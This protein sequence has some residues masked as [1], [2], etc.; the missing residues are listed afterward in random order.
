LLAAQEKKVW[1]E[2]TEW[3]GTRRLK[4]LPAH[5]WTIAAYLRWC[6]HRHRL[7]TL[8]AIL[9]VIARKHL[10]SCL[11]RPDRHPTVV[12]TLGAIRAR[13]DARSRR[14]NLFREAD[15]TAPRAE[16][17]DG[18]PPQMKPRR[19]SLANTPKLVTR[20]PAPVGAR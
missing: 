5:P 3:C 15:F 8:E 17:A 18:V 10:L 6:E 20:R 19:R 12:R 4:S 9:M 2:F 13:Q 7:A 1:K 14:A 11:T 16:V